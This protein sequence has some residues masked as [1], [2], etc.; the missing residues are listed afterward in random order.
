MEFTNKSNDEIV[1]AS[2]AGKSE[3]SE[4]V[5]PKL[6]KTMN[7][8]ATVCGECTVIEE[9]AEPKIAPVDRLLLPGD[10]V[11]ITENDE[12]VYIIGT[13]DGKVTKIGGLSELKKLK[14]RFLL[15]IN[16]YIVL[17]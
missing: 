10:I 17:F 5:V 8:K 9:E 7:T 16:C 1:E 2:D 15:S 12:S 14:V 11:E 6:A 4:E 3:I 13:K